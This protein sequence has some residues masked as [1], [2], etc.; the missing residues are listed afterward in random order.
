MQLSRVI[1]T[2]LIMWEK[3]ALNGARMMNIGYGGKNFEVGKLGE[4]REMCF[5]VADI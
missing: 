5:C 4:M 2:Y 3:L 1:I